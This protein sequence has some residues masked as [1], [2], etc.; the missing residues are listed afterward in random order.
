MNA[1]LNLQDMKQAKIASTSLQGL[2]SHWG[3]AFQL[4]GQIC[5]CLCLPGGKSQTLAQEM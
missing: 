2:V 4:D 5:L 3:G 1:E